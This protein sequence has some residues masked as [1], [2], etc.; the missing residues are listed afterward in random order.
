MFGINPKIAE[1]KIYKELGFHSTLKYDS[2][3]DYAFQE[4]LDLYSEWY[5]IEDSLSGVREF[6]KDK[7]MIFFK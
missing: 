1:S 4:P 2:F 6:L 7:E 5:S 3:N